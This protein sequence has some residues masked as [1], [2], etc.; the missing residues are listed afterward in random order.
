LE[1]DFFIL[2]PKA[3]V[4][5]RRDKETKKYEPERSYVAE[6]QLSEDHTPSFHREA[7]VCQPPFSRYHLYPAAGS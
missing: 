6:V 5:K 4:K 1:I 2:L 3:I 7:A